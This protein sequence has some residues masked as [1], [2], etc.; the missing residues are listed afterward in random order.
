MKL[1]GTIISDDVKWNKNTSYLVKK[2]YSRMEL[3]RR[4]KYFTKSTTDKLQIYK[5]FIRNN[6]EQSCVVWGSSISKKKN[7]DIKRVQKVAVNLILNQKSVL[8]R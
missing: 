4:I 5:K 2:A 7:K 6:F 8:Q 3:L 1:L